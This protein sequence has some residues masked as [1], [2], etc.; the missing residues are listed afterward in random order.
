MRTYGAQ[1]TKHTAVVSIAKVVS[2]RQAALFP[3]H[4]LTTNADRRARSQQILVTVIDNVTEPLVRE[5]ENPGGPSDAAARLVE[6][7][8]D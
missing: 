6:R 3:D 7:P 1:C 5:A 4:R 2:S 8:F